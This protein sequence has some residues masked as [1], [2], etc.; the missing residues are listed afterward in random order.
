MSTRVRRIAVSLEPHWKPCPPPPSVLLVLEDRDLQAVAAR[1]LTSAGFSVSVAAHSGHAVLASFRTVPFDVLVI[2]QRLSEGSSGVI[3]ERLQ[4]YNPG[5]RVIRLCA[6][7]SAS[8][9]PTDLIRPFTGDDLIAAVEAV[10]QR[11][12]SER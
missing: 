12:P 11:S 7:G 1:V 10:A 5:I 6:R 3:T 9:R 8:K 4:R 2:E